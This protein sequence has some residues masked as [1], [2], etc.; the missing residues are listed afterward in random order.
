[1]RLTSL[2]SLTILTILLA[3]CGSSS[4]ED[5]HA[6]PRETQ[7]W[8]NVDLSGYSTPELID[9][10]D[11]L[12]NETVKAA[13][14]GA[15]IEYHH[16]EVAMT[17]AIDALEREFSSNEPVL[18]TLKQLREL[19]MKLHLAGHDANVPMGGKIAEVIKKDL[20]RLRSQIGS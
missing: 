3:G 14:E 10:L 18:A 12:A 7:S 2:F 9:H 1:M 17:P 4:E 8:E 6:L 20:A 13:A 11:M 15:Y 16:L 5:V 19:A